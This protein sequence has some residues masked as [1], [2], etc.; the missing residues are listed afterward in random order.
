MAQLGFFDTHPVCATCKIP[1]NTNS[2]REK[3]HFSLKC[4]KCRCSINLLDGMYLKG[5]DI[6]NFIHAAVGWVTEKKGMSLN[7]ETG[8]SHNTWAGY[9]NILQEAVDKTLEREWASGS[10]KGK[11][12]KSIILFIERR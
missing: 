2:A 10:F 1:F 12:T 9:R 7:T 3:R 11:V 6:R 8:M 4:S 5:L